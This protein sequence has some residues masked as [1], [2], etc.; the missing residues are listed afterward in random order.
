MCAG[1]RRSPKFLSTLSVAGALETARM[2][3]QY[4]HIP[5]PSAARRRKASARH[6]YP[7][8]SHSVTVVPEK[9]D[10][11]LGLCPWTLKS[12]TP[13]RP[14]PAAKILLQLVT[15]ARHGTLLN[16]VRRQVASGLLRVP[17]KRCCSSDQ[18]SSHCRSDG[19][20]GPPLCVLP[21]RG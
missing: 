16:T 20:D 10:P 4:P 21:A 13:L 9:M 18:R 1:L 2:P 12:P 8:L 19:S 14:G 5:F 11:R 7:L 15:C 6:D 3:F 17:R